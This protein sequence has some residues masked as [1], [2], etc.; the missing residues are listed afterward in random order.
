V[1]ILGIE[2]SCDE[3]AAAVV[4]DGRY[5]LSN[6][7]ASQIPIHE[8]FGGV[9]PEVASRQHVLSID[10][11][12]SRALSEAGTTISDVD[13]VAA[14]FGPGLSGPLLVGTSFAKALSL[15]SD[16]PLH[17][18]NHIEGHLLSVWLSTDSESSAPP[19]L[20][21]VSLVVSGGHTELFTIHAPGGYERM[22]RTVD[23]AAGE[24]FDKVGRLLGLPYPGGPNL[25]RAAS[26]AHPNGFILPRAWLPGTYDFS[27]SGLKTAV[28]RHVARLADE[29]AS[30][31]PLPPRVVADVSYAFQESVADVLT[32]KLEQ[33]TRDTG[34]RSAAIVGGVAANEFIR[35]MASER[36]SV[37]LFTPGP[38]L[39]SDNA[40][41]IAAAAYWHPRIAELSDDINPNLRA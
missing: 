32:R 39:S 18:V 19:E 24:A 33:A 27:F 31:A 9:V 36:I 40:A 2:T 41:M 5:V 6:I 21:M 1:I 15:A 17:A 16:L 37:R 12:V 22:G 8:R 29:R 30:N 34:A 11:V 14:T 25:E 23:D 20:P 7:I 38:G 35:A 10:K 28:S 26:E 4:V 13:A 3:T